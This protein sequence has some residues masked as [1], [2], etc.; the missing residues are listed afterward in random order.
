MHATPCVTRTIAYRA[1]LDLFLLQD[2][3][4]YDNILQ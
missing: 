4:R 3:Y 2:V 1:S